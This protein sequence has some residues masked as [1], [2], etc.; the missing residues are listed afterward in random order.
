MHTQDLYDGW[1]L[2]AV[3]GPV[4]ADLVGRR[5][6]RPRP[7]HQP[8]GA[9]RG[10]PHPRPVPRPPTRRTSRGCT[11]PTGRTS[12]TSTSRPAADDERVD[13]VFDGID[14]VATLTLRRPRARPHR[15]PA[16]LL[17]LR[18]PR[19]AS[20]ADDAAP[21]RADSRSA[22]VH[23]EAE[24]ARL[25][26]APARLRRSRSTWSARWPARSAGTGDP[27]CR[28]PACGARSGSSAGRS[29]ASAGVRPL[30]TVDADGHRPRRGARRRRALR[31]ARRRRRRSPS[32][33]HV[34]GADVDRRRC[35]GAQTHR[36]RRP[37]GP[38]RPAVVARR[39]RRAAAVRTSSSPSAA[40]DADGSRSTPGRR[41]IGFRTVELD[42][43][44]RRAR[45]RLHVPRS[46]AGPIFVKGANWIP[47]D[48]LL[49]R[50]TRER[51]AHRLDQAVD[52][53]PQPAA[54]LGR[55]D[56]RVRGL[57]R[58]SA[59]SAGCWSG[60]TSCSPARRTRR[61]SRSGTSS[62][63]RRARTSPA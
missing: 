61:R 58:R 42:T 24:A 59:T 34:A 35:R 63:P 30:V 47:D 31:P 1:T 38:A 36:R 25:G 5:V 52:A 43:A 26:A 17:P 40:P 18:R 23:A 45:H 3:A 53:Q 9:A 50:I 41:R 44:R 54:R 15:Q 48:H 6:P 60:R 4:P 55:R 12:A 10:R 49:T 14:T 22:L 46:T 39:A 28:P 7:G 16:P 33:A 56:L 13:L 19:P 21:A 27:T 62:R 2:T 32:R 20:R 11:A 37:R 29:R 51:L 8:H 57:L